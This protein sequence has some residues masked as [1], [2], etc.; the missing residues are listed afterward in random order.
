MG[1]PFWVIHKDTTQLSGVPYGLLQF[2]SFPT[3]L[4]FS[5]DR[6]IVWLSMLLKSYDTSGRRHSID[7]L[8]WICCTICRTQLL[9]DRLC[10]R[11]QVYSGP[12]MGTCISH[13]LQ[14]IDTLEGKSFIDVPQNVLKDMYCKKCT[15]IEHSGNVHDIDA[16]LWY[17]LPSHNGN[18]YWETNPCIGSI[19]LPNLHWAQGE[20]PVLLSTKATI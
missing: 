1:F 4:Q 13:M 9:N 5:D 19:F 15:F 17:V 14:F 18:M 8:I 16:S 10:I 11:T 6:V 12:I 20:R 2:L 7:S 3:P